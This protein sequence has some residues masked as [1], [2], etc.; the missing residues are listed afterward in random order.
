MSHETTQQEVP[1]TIDPATP[2]EHCP[3]APKNSE[4]N[5]QQTA[6]EKAI[7]LSDKAQEIDRQIPL[8]FHEE[9]TL[10]HD[11][12]SGEPKSFDDIVHRM[13]LA[14]LMHDVHEAESG[15][16]T[17]DSPVHEDA[18]DIKTE[19]ERLEQR[20]ERE[21]VYSSDAT[22]RPDQNGTAALAYP[23]NGGPQHSAANIQAD[24]MTKSTTDRWSVEQTGTARKDEQP[25]AQTPHR[26]APK[27]VRG[28][29]REPS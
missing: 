28:T 5:G 21:K 9:W 16:Q 8:P 7:G 3:F 20:A 22:D 10:E 17:S 24:G 2:C 12:E 27:D 6:P 15:Q 18:L 11:A 26:E 1:Q 23:A 13:A 14:Y 25:L 29:D 4:G 19:M